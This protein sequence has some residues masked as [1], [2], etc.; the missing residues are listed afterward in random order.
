[1]SWFH[2]IRSTASRVA[3][4]AL[5][6]IRRVA[7]N[8]IPDSVQRRVNDFGNWLIDRVGPEQTVQV[9]NE[10][11]EHVRTNQPPDNYSKLERAI[12]L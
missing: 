9:L 8:I 6:R 10:M 1:M 12:P 3:S 11:V 4:T 7:S 5:S 2:R